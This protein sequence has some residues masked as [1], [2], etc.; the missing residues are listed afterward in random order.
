[1]IHF[2]LLRFSTL[3]FQENVQG[4]REVA[5][6]QLQHTVEQSPNILQRQL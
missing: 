5:E 3:E 6:Q 4:S 2:I 1:M